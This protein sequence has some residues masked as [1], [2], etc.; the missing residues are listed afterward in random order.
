M[1]RKLSSA[2]ASEVILQL[3]V[4]QE[5][6]CLSPDE[7]KFRAFL[8][9]RLLLALAAVDRIK[10]RQ[11][12]RLVGIR[13]GDATTKLFFIRANGRRQKNH[14]LY[15]Q[16]DDGV[17][18]SDHSEKA[19][20]LL[21]HFTDLLGSSYHPPL[22]L[23]WDYLQFPRADLSHLDRPFD[24]EELQAV[25]NNMAAKK[26]PGTDGFIG[27]FFRK[28]WHTIKI[29][30]LNALNQ[31][32]ALDGKTW[33]LLNSAYIVL[34]PK[35]DAAIR[36]SNFRPISLTHSV[37]KILGKLLATRFAP[38]LEN[39]ISNSQSAFLKGRCI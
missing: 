29:D 4:T 16:K 5:S 30:L 31:L 14:I 8:K 38:E 12:S 3:D 23:N 26:A 11:K 37:A 27:L 2:I 1:Q 25:V 15:L 35:K 18:P 21:H 6:R 13:A 10:W 36:P 20:I 22:A 9:A 32:S 28:C 19:G 7:F 24:L 33:S 17:V 34:I 39:L